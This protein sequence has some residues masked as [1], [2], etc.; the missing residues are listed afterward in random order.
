MPAFPQLTLYPLKRQTNLRTVVNA[1]ADGH[2]VVFSDPDAASIAW[3]LTGK[4]LTGAEWSAV[5]AFYK[6]VS[7]QWQTFTFLDPAGN[8]LAESEDFGASAWTNG[9]LLALTAGVSDP[10][11]TTRATHVVNG[12]QAAQ[13]VE[14]TLAV[15]GNFKYA[16]SVWA[17]TS[18]GSSV[19]LTAAGVSQTFAL[20]GQWKRI[21]L[22]V[23]AGQSTSSVTFA[24]QLSAGASVDLFGMQVDAQAGASDYKKTGTKGGVYSNSRFAS[25]AFTVTA[26]ST[27]VFDATIR[28]VSMGN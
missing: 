18:S 9:T 24:S 14:Q 26:Q 16:L 15:P 7:G 6:S 17:R 8:L 27:D 10:F 3:E 23:D 11:G 19:T 4:G 1:L 20:T 2:T 13:A 28:I 22:M 12:G 25:D 21:A 5:E